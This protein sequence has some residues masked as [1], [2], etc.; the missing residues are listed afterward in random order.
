M[1][2][3]RPRENRGARIRAFRLVTACGRGLAPRL[4]HR[5]RGAAWCQRANEV[6]KELAKGS[7]GRVASLEDLADQVARL[8]AALGT[9]Q[10]E[11][12]GDDDED[13]LAA[14]AVA[15]E[16]LTKTEGLLRAE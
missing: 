13:Q 12:V 16:Y 8:R 14:A 3:P 6:A 1:P 5:P 2:R 9:V 10:A 7:G 4:A 15:L 11:A